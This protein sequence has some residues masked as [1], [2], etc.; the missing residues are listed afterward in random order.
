MGVIMFATRSSRLSR[1]FF[2]AY[3]YHH[4][5]GI[6]NGGR[7]AVP[8]AVN[9]PIKS[10]MPG[11][12]EREAVQKSIKEFR[13]NPVEIPVVINGKEYFT[14]EPKDIRPP[15]EHG[16]VVGR[17]YEA[18]REQV[19]EAINGSI[20]AKKQW[21]AL[22]VEHRLAIFLRCA[23]LLRTTYRG[24][25]NAATILGQGKNM[26]QAEIDSACELIDFWRFNVEFAEKIYSDQPLSDEGVWN[27]S[28]YR[29][30][31]GFIYA[32]TP[33]NFTAIAA[34][35]TSAPAMMGN[36]NVWKPSAHAML[37]AHWIM[38]I[39][40]A[41][42]LPDGVVNMI[43]GDPVMITEEILNH[44]EFAGI[45]FTGSTFVFRDI[46]KTIGNNIHKYKNYPRIVGETG[47]KDYIFA[48]QSAKVDALATAMVRGAFEYQGQKCSAASRAF[49]PESI[50]PEV[51]QRCADQM[52]RMKVGN[53]E[54]ADTMV[55][56]VI[57]K[58]SFA[59][60]KSYIDYAK[61]HKDTHKIV[62]GGKCD[63][64]VGYFIHPTLIETSDPSSKCLNEEIFAPI[65][66]VY[67]YPDDKLQET[68]QLCEDHAYGL[69]G[70]VFSQDRYALNEMMQTLQY[71][72]GNFYIND[73]PT[74]AVVGQQPFGG[75]RLS[76]TN[77]KAGSYLN[78]LRWVSPKSIKETFNPATDFPYPYMQ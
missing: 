78:L 52:G 74:G 16:T 73:K 77:D 14:G 43:P 3:R 51:K 54:E 19:R 65:L 59:K 58:D 61:E 45:H 31:E 6:A 56:A 29:P 30:L 66:T 71:S 42:G 24:H 20:E 35:L 46:W 37:S 5:H 44:P 64:S 10:Y 63:D 4:I 53:P 18:N 11:S 76:G 39:Y 21:Q 38:Q 27:R 23:E 26:F 72:A 60:A 47:G 15:Y 22:P 32:I 57:H 49:I 67:V 68:L 12:S 70:S 33:F 7:L 28:E 40:K 41:A 34:N 17:Y 9:D 55:G 1:S 36:V 25:L 2:N 50:W 62:A 13:E 69:T 75:S 8:K 48:H